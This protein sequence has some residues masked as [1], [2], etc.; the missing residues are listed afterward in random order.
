MIDLPGHYAAKG[1]G[2]PLLQLQPPHGCGALPPAAV[3]RVPLWGPD[4]PGGPGPAAGR[5]CPT[6]AAS[7]GGRRRK[8]RHGEAVLRPRTAPG[9][10]AGGCPASGRTAGTGGAPSASRG[11]ASAGGARSAGVRRTGGAARRPLPCCGI[12]CGGQLVAGAGRGL[13]GPP[14]AYV[15]GVSGYVHRCSG[16]R[17]ADGLCPG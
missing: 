4:G 13:Q 11:A 15:P 6:G 10:C 12:R 16:G 2:G 5:Q 7:A 8:R 1:H 14:A 3:R 9:T 17:P